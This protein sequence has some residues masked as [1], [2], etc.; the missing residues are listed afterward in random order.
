[1]TAKVSDIDRYQ[2]GLLG[3]GDKLFNG[4]LQE[5]SLVAR[6]HSRIKPRPNSSSCRALAGRV[7]RR[8]IEP[9]SAARPFERWRAAD[10]RGRDTDCKSEEGGRLPYP[11]RAQYYVSATERPGVESHVERQPHDEMERSLNG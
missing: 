9:A 10:P 11:R 3:L 4:R 6:L 8:K 7:R 5:E 1:M 2:R